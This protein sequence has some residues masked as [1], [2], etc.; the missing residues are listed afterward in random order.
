[1][2]VGDFCKIGDIK[3]TIER[4]GMRATQ[5]RTNDRTVVTIPNGDLSSMKIENY[6]YRERFWFH[7]VFNLSVHTT[8]DQIR[9]L[10]RDLRHVLLTH[11]RVNPVPA[12]VRFTE[13]GLNGVKI[14]VFAYVDTAD[15]EVFFEI[16]EELLL[17]MM[18][19]VENSGT[20]FMLP[21]QTI[22]FADDHGLTKQESRI[23][24]PE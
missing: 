18:E 12:R 8:P 16:Q 20:R 5:V 23:I 11:P 14:E 21:S 9:Q 24:S 1:V 6:A 19:V 7:P 22:Y 4:I 13:V 3:G 2:R 17:K 10:I 15:I